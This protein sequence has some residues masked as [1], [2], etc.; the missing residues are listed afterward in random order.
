[1]KRFAN[2][3]GH[4][5]AVVSL[6]GFCLMIVSVVQASLFR[7]EN[8]EGII[9]PIWLTLLSVLFGLSAW[10]LTSMRRYAWLATAG[11]ACSLAAIGVASAIR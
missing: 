7:R 6:A 5:L 10:R 4:F 8:P 11:F 9:L 2:V 3:I 1:M